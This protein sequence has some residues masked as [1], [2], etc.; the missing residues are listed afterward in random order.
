MQFHVISYVCLGLAGGS[1][2][3]LGADPSKKPDASHAMEQAAAAQRQSVMLMQASVETQRQSLPP[4]VPQ[5]KSSSFF[6]LPPPTAEETIVYAPGPIDCDP[7]PLPQLESLIAGAARREELQP[8]LLRSVIKQES[9]FRP[10]AVSPKGAIGLMQ[11]MPATA[12][13]FNLEDVFDPKENVDVGARILKELL[14]RYNGNLAL[15]L[16]A[17][18]AGPSRVD[19]AGGIP[20]I[21]ETTDFVK[22]ILSSLPPNPQQK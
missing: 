3:I 7:V 18:N 1:G 4:Q 14:G 13:Q 17:Y 10:C 15:A 2:L 6:L 22:R 9:G 20:N 19:K 12:A 21:P 11:I 16:G 8:D 5:Q